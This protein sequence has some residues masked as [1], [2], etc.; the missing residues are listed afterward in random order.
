MHH[1]G[2]KTIYEL[3]R[4]RADYAPEAVAICAPDRSALTYAGLLSQVDCV[5]EF[6]NFGGI[7]CGDRIATVLPNGPEMALAFLGVSASAVCAPLNPAYSANEVEFYLANL[8]VKAL[9]VQAGMSSAAIAVAEKHGIPVIELL[10]KP[11][12]A[13]G[14]FTLR[15]GDGRPVTLGR[16]FPQAEDVALILHTS[17]TTSRA[18]LV[19]LTHANLLASAGNIATTLRLSES[20]RCLNVMPLF[21]IHGLVGALLSSVMAGASVICTSGFDSEQFVPWLQTLA[22][23]WYTAVPTMHHAVV[24]RV[25]SNPELV[26]GH[27]LRFIRSSSSAMP[28][29]VI[30]ELEERFQVPVIE[31]YG[32]TEA[33]HK[34]TSNPLPPGQRKLGSVGIAAGPEMSIMDAHGNLL[35]SGEGGEIVI[36]GANVTS[37]YLNSAESNQ[38]SFEGD[39]FRTGD[40]GY[41]DRDGYLFITGR[42]KEIINRGGEKIAP[43][44][45]EDIIIHHPAVAEVIAFAV[46][47]ETLGEDV[48]VAVV[49]RE[50]AAVTEREVQQFVAA[51]LAEFKIPRRVVF[52]DEIPKSATGKPQRVGFAEKLGPLLSSQRVHKFVAPQTQVEKTLAAVWSQVLGIE[53][54]GIQDNFFYLGG[55]SIRATQVISR[56]RQAFQMEISLRSVFEKQ[57]VKELA[58]LITE[59]QAEIAGAGALADIESLS[60]EKSVAHGKH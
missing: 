30:Q 52:V 60:D 31:A 16:G 57:T 5:V 33:A 6:L 46:P 43:R 22:P 1:G 17:G 48:A 54:I 2:N 40:Q 36:R 56:V 7:Y 37:G 21:H 12:A 35:S 47:H 19:P 26:K 3:I 53:R 20:D 49:L 10:P 51:H 41:I 50:K 58:A 29:R 59:I 42:L 15:R 32:M 9:I 11:E 39:W 24:S 34:M 55:D 4:V 14:I 45:I 38:D 44:E 28:L 13:A 8:N 25:R 23:T 27:S 18:K